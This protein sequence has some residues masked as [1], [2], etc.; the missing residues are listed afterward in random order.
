MREKILFIIK[1]EDKSY[2]HFLG[3]LKNDPDIVLASY[4][5]LYK[6]NHDNFSLSLLIDNKYQNIENFTNI[7]FFAHPQG[8]D[9]ILSKIKGMDGVNFF[10][11]QF[12]FSENVNLINNKINQKIFFQENKITFLSATND[13]GKEDV[14]ECIYKLNAGSLGFGISFPNKE[15]KLP[16]MNKFNTFLEKYIDA[17][18]DYRV[19]VINKKSL[20]VVCKENK[21]S[22]IVNYSS[23][24]TFY[25][26]KFPELEI[27]SERICNLLNLDYC[28]IDFVVDQNNQAIYVLEINFFA[29]FKGF[30]SV[31]GE[32]LVLNKIKEYFLLK[33]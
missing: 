5:Y 6:I 28:G 15:G 19:M 17:K 2:Q 25:R 21:D 30:E 27:I 9:P 14:N 4:D 10:N 22:E 7:V 12:L 18:K 23:G 3:Q 33:H 13:F 29:H 16:F 32:N 26:A 24:A 20:G 11:K 8:R 1:T 31:Y